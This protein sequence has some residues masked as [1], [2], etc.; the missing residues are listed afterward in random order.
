MKQLYPYQ[1]EAYN[2]CKD[3]LFS[4]KTKDSGVAVLPTGAGKSVILAHLSLLASVNDPILFVVPSID[5]LRQNADAIR[6]EG[7]D[8]SIY[9]GSI[10]KRD[11]STITVA[12]IM[13]L[14]SDMEAFKNAGIKKV[15]IDECH[16]KA[17]EEGMFKEFIDFIKPDKLLGLTATAFKLKTYKGFQVLRTLDKIKPVIFK[18]FIHITQVETVIKNDRWSEVK[19]MYYKYNKKGLI[20]NSSGNNYTEESIVENNK[21]NN[22]NKNICLLLNKIS[23]EK[24][25]AKKIKILLFTDSVDTAKIIHEWVNKKL[26]IKSVLVTAETNPKDRAN[27]VEQFKDTNSDINLLINYGTYTT[28]FDFPELTHVMLGRPTMS[29]TSYYQIIGRLV[30]KHANK[31]YGV[32]IDFC[33]NYERF[34]N[35]EDIN[36]VHIDGYGMCVLSN[37]KVTTSI[38]LECIGRFTYNDIV[39]PPPLHKTNKEIKL[40]FGKYKDKPLS[41]I[42]YFYINFLLDDFQWIV[43]DKNN[44]IIDELKKVKENTIL[45]FLR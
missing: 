2:D 21:Q 3:F 28:G 23:N 37:D 27:F 5:L 26:K 8:V 15:I 13:S 45:K 18:R 22:V 17:S 32:F 4:N 40:S 42:P 6:N 30:R 35:I 7:A 24:I 1:K 14:N 39:N 29:F 20:V 10:N 19:Y 33:G 38:P 44:E 34:G 31:K 16:Y 12:T 11:I 41:Q 43:N 9:C 36:Y 25:D